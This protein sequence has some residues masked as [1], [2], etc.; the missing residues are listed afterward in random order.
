MADLTSVLF[1][2]VDTGLGSLLIQVGATALVTVALVVGRVRDAILSPFRWVA[3]RMTGRRGET[4]AS[5][6]SSTRS[7]SSTPA[8]VDRSTD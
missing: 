3:S 1:A 7:S 4:V 2:Y 8:P 5:G 6:P